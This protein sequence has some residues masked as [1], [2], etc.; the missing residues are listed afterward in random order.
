[1]ASIDN[2]SQPVSSSGPDVY[3]SAS[4]SAGNENAVQKADSEA[5]C[6]LCVLL[7]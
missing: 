4:L 2:T 3:P 5:R 7:H 1:M 6:M